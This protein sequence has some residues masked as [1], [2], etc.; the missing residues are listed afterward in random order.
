[1]GGVS[2]L[3]VTGAGTALAG[4]AGEG[5]PLSGPVADHA[6]A[7]AVAAVPGGRA[8]EVRPD[9]VRGGAY[10]VDFTPADG[11]AAQ[12]RLDRTFTVLGTQ[13][14]RTDGDGDG[15]GDGDDGDD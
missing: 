14:A 9:T 3:G 1:V 2:V 6:R 13:P 5:G 4:G 7:A 11:T 15:D 12:V 8:G 10:D